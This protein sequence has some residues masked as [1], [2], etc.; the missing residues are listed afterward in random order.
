MPTGNSAPVP[1]HIPA[2][3]GLELDEAH[4]RHLVS[5]VMDRLM[6]IL[7]DLP[8]QPVHQPE[9]AGA[10]ELQALIEPVPEQASNLDDLLKRLFSDC[11]PSSL[12]ATSPGFM[13]YVPGGGLFHA[14]VADLLADTLNRYVGVSAVAGGFAQLEANVLRWFCQFMGLP[15]TAAGF[16]TSGG[17]LA[18][19][20]AVVVARHHQLGEEFSR[21]TL[22]TSDQAHHC[23]AKAAK[24][25]GIPSSNLRVLPCDEKQRLSL[26]HLQE[27]VTA[28]RASGFTPFMLVV[29]AGTTNTGAVDP[30]DVCAEF[31]AEQGL[32]LHVDAA[33]GGFFR[34]TERGERGL[35]G[36]ER[37]DSIALDPH[38][39]LFLPYGTGALLVREAAHLK[40]AHASTADY[41]PAASAHEDV[42]DFGD[43]SPEL[44]RPFRG[45][46]VWL[47]LR[48][49]GV[50]VFREYLNEKLDLAAWLAQELSEIPQLE[51]IAPPQL[52]ILAF[53]VRTPA[54]QSDAVRNEVT[55]ALLRAVNARQRVMLTGTSVGG[56]FVI[57]VAIVS[58]R[59]HQVR[60]HMLLEDIKLGL[61]EL[62]L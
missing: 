31:A 52:S 58:F 32:W 39:T 15:Q 55:E 36:I 20:S 56:R 23:V 4:M 3:D 16:L 5:T 30:L 29:S 1:A 13:G 33:Y 51:L 54:G 45:L 48:L 49:H 46:R 42:W 62:G 19:W 22:Y 53:A 37:A 12:N 43:V 8:T 47:P 61:R 10:D 14:A 38:K 44:T 34:L 57:R 59:T 26:P 35:H 50:G 2:P 9:L 6:P 21:G 17:S 11:L 27:A 18:N 24:L 28:D 40:A 25:A 41:L 60:I 7:A